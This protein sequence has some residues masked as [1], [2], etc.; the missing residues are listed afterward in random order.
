MVASRFLQ[1]LSL[2]RKWWLPWFVLVHGGVDGAAM[3]EGRRCAVV[4]NL[5][6][7]SRLVQWRSG[8]RVLVHAKICDG[9]DR[10]RWL[11]VAG[12]ISGVNEEDDGEK[13]EVRWFCRRLWRNS[14]ELTV[15]GA[16]MAEAR[17]RRLAPWLLRDLW[18]PEKVMAAAAAM[19]MEGE[20]KIRVR[21]L[22]D[23]DDDVAAFRWTAC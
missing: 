7:A 5:K 23:E 19:V 13:M 6:V 17:G 4:V 22:G 20:E 8:S 11:H 21:V 2:V 16:A 1:V 9:R 14:S 15:E 18:W 3:R 10:S 12:A